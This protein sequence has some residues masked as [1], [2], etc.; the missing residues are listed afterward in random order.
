[1]ATFIQGSTDFIP[2]IQPWSPDFNFYQNVMATKQSQYDAGWEKTNTLYNSLLNAPMLREDDIAKRDQFFNTIEQDINRLSGID[3]SKQQNVDAAAQLFT[4]IIEDKGIINDIAKTKQ[5]SNE[6]QIMEGYRNCMDPK[7]CGG[8][9][10]E[11]GGRALNYW[12]EDFK[13]ASAD[14]ALAMSG[15][16]YTPYTN[17]VEKAFDKLFTNSDKIGT[18]I[19]YSDGKFM[20]TEKNNANIIQPLMSY[21][22][23]TVGNDPAVRAMYKTKAYVARKDWMHANASQYGSMEEAEADYIQNTLHP[24]TST[25][26]K[27]KDDVTSNR[28]TREIE[29]Q[30]LEEDIS[31]NGMVPKSKE[32]N[33]YLN[34]LNDLSTTL[35]S[36]VALE[37][38]LESAKGVPQANNINVMRFNADAA[39][40][41]AMLYNDMA[42]VAQTYQQLT[43]EIKQGG[44]DPYALAGYNSKLRLN[45]QENKALLDMNMEIWKDKRKL[46]KE[47]ES[48]R[49]GADQ[50][51]TTLIDNIWDKVTETGEEDVSVENKKVGGEL[52]TALKKPQS[53]ALASIYNNFMAMGDDMGNAPVHDFLNIFLETLNKNPALANEKS[54]QDVFGRDLLERLIN[55]KQ[56][57]QMPNK[58]FNALKE[59][60]NS[61]TAAKLAA[62]PAELL[63]DMYAVAN[64]NLNPERGI[65]KKKTYAKDLWGYTEAARNEADGAAA[66]LDIYKESARTS[67]YGDPNSADATKNKGLQST[68]KILATQGIRE[69]N[70]EFKGLYNADLKIADTK[71][72]KEFIDLALTN[73]IDDDGHQVP[74][75]EFAAKMDEV[76]RSSIFETEEEAQADDDYVNNRITTQQYQHHKD[77][78][79]RKKRVAIRRLY[80]G[81]P[82]EA[83]DWDELVYDFNWYSP[84]NIFAD[85]QKVY[86]NRLKK[87]AAQLKKIDVRGKGTGL[88]DL[89]EWLYKSNQPGV[90]AIGSIDGGVGGE[91]AGKT[92]AA[93]DVSP[94][95]YSSV[96]YQS[97]KSVFKNLIE[98]TSDIQLQGNLEYMIDLGLGDD[99]TE[100]MSKVRSFGD[101]FYNKK[102]TTEDDDVPSFDMEYTVNAKEGMSSVLIRFDEKWLEDQPWV[103]QD[104]KDDKTINKNAI[105]KLSNTGMLLYLPKEKANNNFNS[106]ANRTTIDKLLHAN[107]RINMNKY[108]S[109]VGDLSIIANQSNGPYETGYTIGGTISIFRNGTYHKEPLSNLVPNIEAILS[110]PDIDAGILVNQLTP[111]L[112]NLKAYNEQQEQAY[113][114]KNGTKDVAA[115]KK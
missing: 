89:H 27:V 13:N 39:M 31:V 93:F 95:T 24:A 47:L 7:K 35:E 67:W 25:L 101:Y 18:S 22:A 17:A 92:Q 26:Q 48:S 58:V 44:A 62:L 20:V 9:Y 4:P 85:K 81:D 16:K 77:S 36:E 52:E 66:T 3:L 102:W 103:P 40:A 78:V 108:V 50:N 71:N 34:I 70:P 10:W 51:L 69:V 115:L 14:D 74:Y 2:Q 82:G 6:M 114:Q 61:I 90:R 55:D 12:A 113:K 60:R 98:N 57:K 63:N 41:D 88:D 100:V 112:K 45:E 29:T 110:S 56:F 11:E 68:F 76:V 30:I 1:M 75:E 73:F 32:H 99:V 105:S 79:K 43:H 80:H 23:G 46:A 111:V 59:N 54:V 8:K 87:S 37:G 15:P 84:N 64:K 86:E 65:N 33:E 42:G 21:I 94:I 5:L 49:G 104:T 38:Q 28:K 109:N 96:N 53:E 107:G 72:Q 91:S 106:K 19:T 83:D 97:T